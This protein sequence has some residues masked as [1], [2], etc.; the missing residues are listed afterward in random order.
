MHFT[1]STLTGII[2]YIEW[3]NQI[4]LEGLASF[5]RTCRSHGPLS[6][7][8]LDDEELQLMLNMKARTHQLAWLAH[9]LNVRLMID[10]EHTYFQPAIDSLVCELQEK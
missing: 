3:A 6:E 8:R 9:S 1:P 5:T 7:A 4:R 10:A 2:D